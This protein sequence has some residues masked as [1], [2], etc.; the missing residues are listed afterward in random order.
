MNDDLKNRLASIPEEAP[1]ADDLRMLED[2]KQIN[3]GSTIPLEVFMESLKGY[4][5]KMLL[6]LPKSLHKRLAEEARIEG[7]SLNQ[8]ALYKLSR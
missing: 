2:A 5:G 6:R 3:D 1:D 8:Y 4:S 7:I